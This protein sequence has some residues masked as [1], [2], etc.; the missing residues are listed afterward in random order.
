MGTYL[1]HSGLREHLVPACGAL[2]MGGRQ[3]DLHLVA[4]IDLGCDQVSSHYRVAERFVTKPADGQ[5]RYLPD[6]KSEHL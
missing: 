3:S 1:S 2:Q 5:A 6:A 4:G